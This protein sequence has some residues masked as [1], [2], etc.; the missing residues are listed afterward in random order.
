MEFP[1]GRAS[2]QRQR[3]GAGLD[4]MEEIDFGIAGKHARRGIKAMSRAEL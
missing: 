2:R 3:V 1:L 4:A